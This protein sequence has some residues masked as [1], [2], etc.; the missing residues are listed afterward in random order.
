[1]G[2]CVLCT[3]ETAHYSMASAERL[4]N[5]LDGG[6]VDSFLPSLDLSVALA[7]AYPI[8][9]NRLSVGFSEKQ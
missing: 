8:K 6:V 4:L 5:R 9:F 7:Q 1:V 3:L 2:C